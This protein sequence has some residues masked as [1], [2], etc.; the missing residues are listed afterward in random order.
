M[1]YFTHYYRSLE[2]ITISFR[3]IENN[4]NIRLVSIKMK[5]SAKYLVLNFLVLSFRKTSIKIITCNRNLKEKK[6]EKKKAKGKHS[7]ACYR[8]NVLLF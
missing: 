1:L 7:S 4:S 3:K 5:P 6:K 2:G 8:L